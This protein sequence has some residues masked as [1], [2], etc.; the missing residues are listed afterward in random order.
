[1]CAFA[2]LGGIFYGSAAGYINGVSGSRLFIAAVEGANAKSL[3]TSHQSL[4]VSILSCGT[5]FGKFVVFFY[6]CVIYFSFT[7]RGFDGW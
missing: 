4:I 1:M 6:S 2:T 7:C 5:F 3:N